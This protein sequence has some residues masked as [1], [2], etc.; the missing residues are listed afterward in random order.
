[1]TATRRTLVVTNDFPPRQGGIQSFVH[2][3]LVRQPAGLGGR[4][5]LDHAGRGRLR[6]RAAVPGRAPPDRSAAAYP[7]RA[8]PGGRALREPSAPAVWFGAAAPLGL[9]APALRAAGAER[10]VATTHGHEAGWATLPGARQLLR[11]IGDRLR[12]RHLSRR[13]HPAAPRRPDRRHPGSS[14]SHLEWTSRRSV[15]DV[16][17]GRGAR[18]VRAGGAAGDRL[19]LPAGAPQGPGPLHR[20]AA[21]DPRR[22]ARTRRCCS[23]AT[24]PTATISRRARDAGRRRRRRVHRRRR[25]RRPAGALRGRRRVRHA[26]PH[27]PR[28]AGRRGARHRLPRGVGHRAA[29]ARRRLGRRAGRRARGRDRLRRRRAGRRT[30]S[31]S[32]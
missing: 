15:P 12:R 18:A 23:S 5:R 25:A 3:L 9:L 24:V 30:R 10:V 8:A 22:G 20:R 11:R 26:L 28:R 31:P 7:G 17:G 21:G 4:L 13:L 6:R 27:P 19:R 2:Q 14:G 32:G 1:M 29:G 16:D